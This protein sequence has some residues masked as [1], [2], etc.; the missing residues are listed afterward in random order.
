[1]IRLQF[2]FVFE[3]GNWYRSEMDGAVDGWKE[4]ESD[5]E[6]LFISFRK[7]TADIGSMSKTEQTLLFFY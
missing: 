4:S 2:E 6:E 7:T 1:M 3:I 5:K